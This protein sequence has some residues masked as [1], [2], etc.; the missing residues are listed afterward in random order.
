MARTW[1]TKLHNPRAYTC[2]CLPECFCKRS[3]IGHT[4]M[5]YVPER[6]H[7]RPPKR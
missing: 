2:D 1:L 4:L 7:R 5:W 3:K 6:F